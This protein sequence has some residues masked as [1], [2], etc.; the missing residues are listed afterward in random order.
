MPYS[1]MKGEL[2]EAVQNLG[3]EKTVLVKPGLIVGKRE[4]FRGAEWAL[5]TIAQFLGSIS[6]GL[7]KDF[8]AQDA[9]VIGRAAMM[10]GLKCLDGTAPPGNTWVV[11]M[12]DI[13][14]LGRTEWNDR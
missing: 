10:A 5:R 3:F 12:G 7:L 1:K 4:D 11:G 8:W 9:D 2:D 6:G 14:R 13:I